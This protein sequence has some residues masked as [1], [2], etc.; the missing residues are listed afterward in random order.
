MQARFMVCPPLGWMGTFYQTELATDTSVGRSVRLLFDRRGSDMRNS[1]R[2]LTW[3]SS[4]SQPGLASEKAGPSCS[5]TQ[6]VSD[7]FVQSFGAKTTADSI[8]D[9]SSLVDCLAWADKIV[10]GGYH[11]LKGETEWP[12][13]SLTSSASATWS[14]G[15]SR[16]SSTAS[17]SPTRSSTRTSA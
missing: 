14:S 16:R 11:H 5:G 2:A 17:V 6:V 8:N 10:R 7:T 12:Q 1:T 15:T 9:S 3:A 4:N 13:P